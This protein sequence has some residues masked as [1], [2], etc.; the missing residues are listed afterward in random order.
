MALKKH[1]PR[2]LQFA[3]VGAICTGLSLSLQFVFLKFFGTPLIPTYVII[4][5]MTILLSYY[6]NSRYSFKSS[7]SFKKAVKYYAIYLSAMLLGVI[8]LKIYTQVM[9]FEN[10][11][12]PFFVAP[13]TMLW[14][15][16]WS[17]AVLKP[18]IHES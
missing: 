17:S 13:F 3:S 7:I 6:L 14:N 15:Y 1:I 2:F 11:V 4:Y 5:G 16:L 18:S 9:D 12:Y 10:W 8:L